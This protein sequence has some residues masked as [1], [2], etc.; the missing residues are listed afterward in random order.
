MRQAEPTVV[1]VALAGNPNTGKSTLFNALTGLNQHTGNWPG[2]TVLRAEGTFRHGGRDYLVVDLPGT[3]SLSTNSPE[4]EVA[5]DFICHSRPDVT[6]VVADATTIERNLY[7]ALQILEITPRVVVCLNLVD[8]AARQGVVVDG[9][10]LAR[11]LGVPVVPTVARNGTGL[12]QLKEVIARVAN[13]LNSPPAPGLP[14]QDP[15]DQDPPARDA[16]AL[17]P[18]QRAVALFHRAEEIAARAICHLPPTG[19]GTGHPDWTHRLDDMLTSRWLGFPVMFLLLGLVFWITLA[20]ANYPSRLLAAVFFWGEH[21]LTELSLLLNIPSWLH[22]VVILG[23]FR[24]VAWVVSVMLPP[25]A[26]FFP[27]FALLEDAG[28]LPRVAFNVDR[29]FRKMGAHGKQSLTMSMGFGCN[30]A[31]VVSCRIIESPRER[32]IAMLTNNFIPCNG[33]FPTLVALAAL[34]V[35]GTSAAT[36]G[37]WAGSLLASATVTALV[38]VGIATSLVVSWTLSR[39]L[40]R[41]VPSSFTLELPPY[42]HPQVGRVLVRSFLDRTAFCLKRAVTVAAPAGALTWLLANL[43]VGSQSA[44]THM[45]TFLQPI[46][47]PLGLDGFILTAFILGLPANEIVLPIL[48]MSYLSA[49]AMV[50]MESLATLHTLLTS[51]GWTPATALCVMLFSVLHFPCA[52]T[53]LTI[54]KESGS[55]RWTAFSI[56]I[57]TAVAALTCFLVNM[58]LSWAGLFWPGLSWAGLPRG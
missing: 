51:H 37:P 31:G 19:I 50:E 2:K 10:Q 18:M 3:Y 4:E 11:E 9:E 53:V 17:D 24:T 45:A 55:R 42:R 20:G 16:L 30:A 8:E 44:I 6:V 46:A 35:A 52:T 49:G 29:I 32:A 1:R 12:K 13:G 40:L 28:Y 21:R 5:R 33:R 25:M 7:L 15:P 47:A 38:L 48:L 23:T 41:G 27:C 56:L 26:I 43:T 39:T 22:G 57:P 58:S 54:W 14:A 34:F 36:R